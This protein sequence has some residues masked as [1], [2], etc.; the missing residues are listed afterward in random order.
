MLQESALG[1]EKIF[2]FEF[3]VDFFD[4][5]REFY[6]EK[7]GMAET[8]RSTPDWEHKF[9]SRGIYF[10]AGDVRI[11]VTCPLSSHSYTAQYLKMLCPGVRT[12]TFKVKDLKK[13]VDY[14]KT[15][16]AT[17][18]HGEKEV[19]SESS[20]HRFVT[21]ATPIGFLE[22]TFVEIEGEEN[23]I[24]MFERL[25]DPSDIASPF[26]RIDH[27][28]VNARTIFPISSFF[29]HVMGFQQFWT[30]AFHTPDYKSG[31]KGTGLSS[32]VMWDPGSQTKFALNEPLYPHFNQSQIQT[33]VN[34]NHGA[35]V[36][37]VALS[38]PDLISTVREM[39]DRGIEFLETPDA[40]YDLLPQRIER[41][42]MG[43]IREDMEGLKRQRI[44]VDGKDGDYLLQI[45]LKDASLLYQEDQAGPF[46]YEVIQRRGHDGFGEGNF[47]ALF[48]AIELQ[49]TGS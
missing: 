44:L 45:F 22:F 38:V 14:L 8:H 9:S 43:P 12:V 20:V 49:E 2:S 18:V 10:G 36:Q 32:K 30:V 7:M 15:H 47:R 25:G 11:L 39:R 27:M 6:I 26:Q 48:E 28:T 5:S 16:N 33:F 29:E 24:P 3:V 35:G 13:T 4:R 19:R 40:Y 37:H 1:I 41:S 46:F 21:I 23:D 31:R 34:K 42:R 17:F